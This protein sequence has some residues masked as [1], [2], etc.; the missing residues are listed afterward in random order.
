MRE[1]SEIISF[2]NRRLI[3][4]TKNGNE[5]VIAP[6]VEKYLGVNCFCI[7]YVSVC[8]HCSFLKEVLFPHKIKVEDAMYC[9]YCNP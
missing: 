9:N 8:D 3:I 1:D 4:A 6:I 7:E 2:K 5:N